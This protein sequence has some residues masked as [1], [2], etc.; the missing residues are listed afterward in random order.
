MTKSTFDQAVKRSKM[1]SNPVIERNPIASK[2]PFVGK[3][4]SAKKPGSNR[5]A[6]KATPS[7]KPTTFK[8][9]P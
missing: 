4:L 3:Y 6:W 5:D 2:L 8:M 1:K 7:G 9:V